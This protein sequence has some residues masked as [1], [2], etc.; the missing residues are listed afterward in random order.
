MEQYAQLSHL[1][2]VRDENAY[3][4]RRINLDNA[5]EQEAQVCM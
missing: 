1:R 3:I 4:E 2:S 5:I